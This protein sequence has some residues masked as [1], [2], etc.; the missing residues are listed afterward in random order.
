MFIGHMRGRTRARAR[1]HAC[2]YAC[3]QV[4]GVNELAPCASKSFFRLAWENLQDPILLL[5]LAAALVGNHA[6][7]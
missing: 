7:M 4:F 1:T 2:M 5:L 6:C 3:M